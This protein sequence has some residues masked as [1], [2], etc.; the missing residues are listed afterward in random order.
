M[1]VSPVMMAVL[2]VLMQRPGPAP[3]TP[4]SLTNAKAWYVADDAQ[5]TVTGGLTTALKEK[6][7]AYPAA[8][9]VRGG[10]VMTDLLNGRPTL[11]TTTDGGGV[12]ASFE[13]GEG[14]ASGS[15]GVSFFVVNRVVN[16]NGASY[17]AVAAAM[18]D[19][20]GATLQTALM[21]SEVG[22][23]WPENSVSLRTRPKPYDGGLEI[24][25]TNTYSDWVIAGASRRYNHDDG[26]VWVN[27]TQVATGAMNAD[28]VTLTGQMTL[29]IGS[30]TTETFDLWSQNIAEVIAVRGDISTEDRQRIEGY[31]AW[32]WGLQANLP[33]GHP[34][35]TAAPLVG[36]MPPVDPVEDE[37][38]LS[39]EA[40]LS[41]ANVDLDAGCS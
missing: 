34:F 25:T 8:N 20:A 9:A 16:R 39:I 27:G 30:Y 26:F 22:T 31:L 2:G 33:S 32:Q 6:S 21:R 1:I 41:T 11:R 29:V 19:R 40:F 36:A 35:K 13:A 24:G 3:W 12:F 4:A 23:G 28:D 18:F 14:I 5:N 17:P 10:A 15:P 38:T 7:G 37:P